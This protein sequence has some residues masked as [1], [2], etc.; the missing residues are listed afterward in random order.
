MKIFFYYT[1]NNRIR[2]MSI[3]S[4]KTDFI[5]TEQLHSWTLPSRKII[6]VG[7]RHERRKQI[8]ISR[9]SI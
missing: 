6:P 4:E 2:G 8:T 3:Q 5:E 1:P 9:K 7:N